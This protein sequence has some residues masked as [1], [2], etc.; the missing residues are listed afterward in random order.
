MRSATR[1]SLLF[2]AVFLLQILPAAAIEVV[3]DH[4]DIEGPFVTGPDVTAV[5]LECH[6]D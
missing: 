6:E 2:L 4:Q 3:E 1:F 5:C